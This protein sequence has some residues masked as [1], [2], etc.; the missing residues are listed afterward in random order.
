MSD[1]RGKIFVVLCLLVGVVCALP[2]K[3]KDEATEIDLSQLGER[4]YG[5]PDEANGEKLKYLTAENMT[6]NPE[7]MGSYAEGDILHLPSDLRN[8]V[9]APAKRW[10]NGRVPYKLAGFFSESELKLG[11]CDNV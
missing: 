5:E 7:E 1:S 6:G 4:I 8:G 3:L 9:R 10:P 11:E 2:A